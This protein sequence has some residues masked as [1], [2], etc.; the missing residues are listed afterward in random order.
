MYKINCLNPIAKCGTDLFGDQY[1]LTENT[2]EADAILVRSA[3]MHELELS[4]DTIAVAR[5]SLSTSTLP[6]VS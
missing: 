1:A 6:R 3:Q 4:K 5:A 2:N